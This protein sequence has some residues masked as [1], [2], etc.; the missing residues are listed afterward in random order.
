MSCDIRNAVENRIGCKVDA[1][2]VRVEIPPLPFSN[3]LS[4]L[5][6][7]TINLSRL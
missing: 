7:S 2:K 5:S 6:D 3:I 1:A 4:S